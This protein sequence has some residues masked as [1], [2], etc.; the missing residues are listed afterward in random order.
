MISCKLDYLPPPFLPFYTGIKHSP[1]NLKLRQKESVS[2]DGNGNNEKKILMLKTFGEHGITSLLRVSPP[3]V[4]I[5]KK[6][7]PSSSYPISRL[8]GPPTPPFPPPGSHQSCSSFLSPTPP[9]YCLFSYGRRWRWRRRR[10]QEA[11]AAECKGGKACTRRG[12]GFKGGK[13]EDGR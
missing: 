4:Y 1:L 12:G 6:G 10:G 2:R 8:F 3:P 9:F 13:E 11:A 5:R 7:K